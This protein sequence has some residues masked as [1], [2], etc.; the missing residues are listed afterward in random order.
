MKISSRMKTPL[1]LPSCIKVIFLTYRKILILFRIFRFRFRVLFVLLAK[2]MRRRRRLLLLFLIINIESPLYLSARNFGC[3]NGNGWFVGV[4]EGGSNLI[5][6]WIFLFLFFISC[7]GDDC[8]C[9]FC[10][11]FCFCCCAAGT[12]ALLSRTV[13]ETN[14]GEG[15]KGGKGG[16][17]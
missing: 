8:F 15:G 14:L 7:C 3:G 5:F 16:G 4:D 10:C 6:R 13:E 2:K 9:C 12:V 17:G 11:C 1:S